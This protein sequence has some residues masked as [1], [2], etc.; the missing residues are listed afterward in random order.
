VSRPNETIKRRLNET[1]EDL[2]SLTSEELEKLKEE[3]NR[4]PIVTENISDFTL[5]LEY[6]EI[7]LP[8]DQ[9]QEEDTI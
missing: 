2:E 6:I 9:S 1:E 4:D 3:G 8:K 7:V 5:T